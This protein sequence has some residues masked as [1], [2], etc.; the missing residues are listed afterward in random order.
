MDKEKVCVLPPQILQSIQYL[1]AI[2]GVEYANDFTIDILKYGIYGV[3]IENSYP[4]IDLESLIEQMNELKSSYLGAKKG[5]R[6]LTID[7]D[8]QLSLENELSN[9]YTKYE[10]EGAIGLVMN[11]KTGEILAMSSYPSFNPANY[12]EYSTEVINRNLTIWANFEPGS[13][14]KNV[15]LLFSNYFFIYKYYLLVMMIDK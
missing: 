10:A 1:R 5:G 4:E 15:T 6:K 8:I 7:L 2:K 12:K 14:F 9:A 13:T 3:P 11:P